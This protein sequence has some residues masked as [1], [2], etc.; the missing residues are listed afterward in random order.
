MMVGDLSDSM[1]PPRFSL[2]TR[3]P[4]KSTDVT[5]T[6]TVRLADEALAVAGVS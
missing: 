4:T 2:I 1:T 5:G 6:F 3:A